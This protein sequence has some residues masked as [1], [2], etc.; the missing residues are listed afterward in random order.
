MFASQRRARRNLPGLVG[1]YRMTEVQFN[2]ALRTGSGVLWPLTR[3]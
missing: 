3:R 1:Y 2:N